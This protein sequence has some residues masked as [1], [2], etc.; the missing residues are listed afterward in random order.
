M[1]MF[2]GSSEAPQ[3]GSFYCSFHNVTSELLPFWILAAWKST[4]HR[5]LNLIPPPGSLLGQETK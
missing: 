5:P 1:E 3:L 4:P 2:V